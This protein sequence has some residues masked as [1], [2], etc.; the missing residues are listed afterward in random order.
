MTD[1]PSKQR[2]LNGLHLGLYREKLGDRFIIE[3]KPE[4][5]RKKQ[6]GLDR[7]RTD[8]LYTASVALSQLSYEPLFSDADSSLILA[9][10]KV[11]LQKSV[12]DLD[13]FVG[14]RFRLSGYK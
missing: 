3:A 1:L 14:K 7:D 13:H 10:R 2:T 6:S 8:D 11:N 9:R 12:T 5:A 4:M